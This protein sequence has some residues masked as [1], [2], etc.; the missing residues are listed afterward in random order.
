[1][2]DPLNSAN[3]PL[4][5]LHHTSLDRF[6]ALWQ[7]QDLKRLEAA[8]DAMMWVGPMSENRSVA[9][10]FD[11]QNRN[12]KGYLCYKYEGLDAKYYTS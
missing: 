7:E 11:T 4:F 12:G 8:T 10:V 9:E 6:W 5:W 2:L 3:D 1:M